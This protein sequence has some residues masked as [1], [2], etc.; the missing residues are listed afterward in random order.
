MGGY[1]L[2][3]NPIPNTKV[4]YQNTCFATHCW[5]PLVYRLPAATTEN[6][7]HASSFVPLDP[8]LWSSLPEHFCWHQGRLV[9][10]LWCLPEKQRNWHLGVAL[11]QRG[12]RIGEL[13]SSLPIF[14]GRILRRIL[15]WLFRNLDLVVPECMV[16][17]LSP[18]P[19]SLSPFF[20]SCFLWPSAK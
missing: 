9:C 8:Q 15:S 20:P 16:Y 11:Y 2:F 1:K 14:H 19:I 7:Q 3:Q 5:W 12:V 10:L 4:P 13:M 17:L 18:F 6:F